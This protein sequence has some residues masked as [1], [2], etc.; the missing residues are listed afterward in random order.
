M[1]IALDVPAERRYFDYIQG[2]N[3][4]GRTAMKWMALLACV[5][6]G[7]A[8]ASDPFECVDPDLVSAF[9]GHR[10][11]GPASYST[12]IPENFVLLDMPEGLALVGSE[13]ADSRSEVVFKTYRK[14]AEAFDAAVAKMGLSGWQESPNDR[15]SHQR[16]FQTR[17]TSL[18]VTLCNADETDALAIVAREGRGQT[19][20]SYT[21]LASGHA[22]KVEESSRLVLRLNDMM[23][24]EMPTMKLPSDV[25]PS[26]S[27]MNGGGDEF[28]SRVDVSGM[29][30]RSALQSDLER[31][32]RAQ[33]WEFQTGWT[34]RYSTGSVWT[35]DAGE[36]GL[37]VGT[38]HFYGGDADPIRIRY[39]ITPADPEKGVD[40]GGWSS[41]LSP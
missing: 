30:N 41:S 36:R 38:L 17:S 27:G 26:N 7:T 16:G 8:L 18:A 34:S 14:P 20:V 11:L 31:Q 9:V 28:S 12:E 2:R 4:I 6:S 19:L 21:Q 29:A 24:T 32:I 25:K 13:I 37:L 22:C 15:G 1:K 5:F 23:L 3:L 33:G 35:K 40:R 10:H 39:S